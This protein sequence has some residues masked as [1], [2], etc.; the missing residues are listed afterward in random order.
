MKINQNTPNYIVKN[1][2]TNGVLRCISGEIPHGKTEKDLKNTA[3]ILTTVEKVFKYSKSDLFEIINSKNILGAFLAPLGAG[4]YLEE[5]NPILKI[6]KSRL[7]KAKEN[8]NINI[9]INKLV[10]EIGEI[11]NLNA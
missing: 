1:F 7:V 8:G 2:P 5:A 9:E 10:K 4:K 3:D 11:I 6:Y